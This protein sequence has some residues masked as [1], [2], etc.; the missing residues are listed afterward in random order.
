[1]INISLAD[2]YGRKSILAKF[3]VPFSVVGYCLCLYTGSYVAICAGFFLIGFTRVKNTTCLVCSA[4]QMEA[5]KAVYS[6]TV[7]LFLDASQ[8]AFLCLFI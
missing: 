1:M 5:D 8:A 7:L 6:N 4:E 2:M 3:F